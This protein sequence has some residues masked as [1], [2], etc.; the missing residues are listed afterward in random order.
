MSLEDAE[1]LAILCLK[2]VMEEKVNNLSD[3][4]LDRSTKIM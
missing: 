2:S 3:L 4:I 1:K